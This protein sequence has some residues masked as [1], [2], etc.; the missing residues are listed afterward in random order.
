MPRSKL[1]LSKKTSRKRRVS[2]RFRKR[3]V[4]LSLGYRNRKRRVSSSLRSRK[5]RVP[6][7]SKLKLNAGVVLESKDNNLIPYFNFSKAD[8]DDVLY[9][10]HV[11]NSN[12]NE[13]TNKKLKAADFLIQDESESVRIDQFP[14]VFLSIVTRQNESDPGLYPGGNY[15]MYFSKN[16]LKQNNFHINMGDFQGI[17]AQN[18]TYYPWQLS[19]ALNSIK[20]FAEEKTQE[21]TEFKMKF[22][23]VEGKNSVEVVFHD[24]VLFDSLFKIEVLDDNDTTTPPKIIYENPSALN[25]REDVTKLPFFVF[26]FEKY[27]ESLELYENKIPR[28]DLSFFRAMGRLANLEIKDTDTIEMI[29]N[30]LLNGVSET[31]YRNRR[32]QNLDSFIGSYHSSLLN[33]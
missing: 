22:Q 29:V 33:V 17:V 3:R 32:L 15:K 25:F 11:T 7:I 4:S 1:K 20:R 18:M 8:L 23:I 12:P 26:P 16:L 5:R 28:S 2:L 24:D 31:M 13:W 9:L 19:T 6:P 21:D 14:G 30:A 10:V 27:Y